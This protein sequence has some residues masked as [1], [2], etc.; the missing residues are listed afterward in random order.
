MVFEDF[1]ISYLSYSQFIQLTSRISYSLMRW[2]QSWQSTHRM[3]P[4]LYSRPVR[5]GT[6]QVVSWSVC[7]VT[8]VT[9][10]RACLV[11]DEDL[12]FVRLSVLETMLDLLFGYVVILAC[13]VSKVPQVRSVLGTRVTRGLSV[14]SIVMELY[15]SVRSISI[16]QSINA[17]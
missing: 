8:S 12:K 7:V 10:L 14:T 15:W 1:N 17:I 11:R 9:L 3:F 2:P 6:D 16:Y 13:G 5:A 4:P